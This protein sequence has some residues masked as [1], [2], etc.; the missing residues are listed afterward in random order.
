MSLRHRSREQNARERG[1]SVH[2]SPARPHRA[3]APKGPKRSNTVPEEAVQ[4]RTSKVEWF[5]AAVWHN[6]VIKLPRGLLVLVLRCFRTGV[7]EN[8]KQQ[9]LSSMYCLCVPNTSWPRCRNSDCIAFVWRPHQALSSGSVG[10]FFTV[11][12]ALFCG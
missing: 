1:S 7:G 9:K 12:N 11:V 3:Q 2:L 4:N 5:E 8:T 10:V 6:T